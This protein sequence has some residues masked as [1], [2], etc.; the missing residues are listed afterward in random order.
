MTARPPVGPLVTMMRTPALL[1]ASAFLLL[2]PA[3]TA[4]V[5]ELPGGDMPFECLVGDQQNG[6]GCF[7]PGTH[8]FCLVRLHNGWID[9]DVCP[10]G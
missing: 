8:E 1:L 4:Q 6:V 9:A 2:V 5:P 3:A 7:D 10:G